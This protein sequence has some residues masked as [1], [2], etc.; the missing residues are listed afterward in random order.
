MTDEILQR[1]VVR[2]EDTPKGYNALSS[3]KGK[4]GTHRDSVYKKIW[5]FASRGKIPSILYYADGD[6][7]KKRIYVLNSSAILVTVN[8]KNVE[9]SLLKKS[10]SEPGQVIPG[11]SKDLFYM[12]IKRLENLE[13]RL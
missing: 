3:Y 13:E 7:S 8:G 11:L 1:V 4:R 2:V 6:A 12:I 5:K 9:G 10:D